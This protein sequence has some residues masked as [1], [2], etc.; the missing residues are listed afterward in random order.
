MYRTRELHRALIAPEG[1]IEARR[2]ETSLAGAD[3]DRGRSERNGLDVQMADLE[4]MV[5]AAVAIE[6]ERGAQAVAW[7]DGVFVPQ[8]PKVNARQLFSKCSFVGGAGDPGPEAAGGRLT[9]VEG[10][11]CR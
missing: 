4:R 1:S 6:A 3:A 7:C 9:A 8:K 11:T 10:A 2:V 5:G